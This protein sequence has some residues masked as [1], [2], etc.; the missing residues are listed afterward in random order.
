[1]SGKNVF[2]VL[3]GR[4]WLGSVFLALVFAG[5]AMAA[6]V[7]TTHKDENGW[8]LLV[9]GK[10]YYVKGM[11]WSY[12]PRGEN[13]TYDLWGQPDEFVKKILDYDFSL[14]EKAGVNTIRTFNSIPPKWVT[15][16]YQEY[17]IRTIVNHLAARYGNSYT[18][19]WVANTNYQ[20]P[21]TRAAMK[22]DVLKTVE[23]FKNT[24]GLLMF[25]LGNEANYGLSWSSFE[26]ENFPEGEQNK[27]KA[28]YLYSIYNE[29]IV[30][31]KKITSDVPYTIVNGD[32]QYIDLIKE[33]CTDLDVLGTNVYRG[34]SF[35][36]LWKD[37]DEKLD[38]PVV[39]MEFGSDAFN[40]RTNSEDQ[41]SQAYLLKDQWQELYNKSYGNGEEGNS[42]GGTVFEWRD[43]WWKFKQTENLDKQDNNA[44]WA[45]GGYTSDFREGEN[46]MNEEWWG[47]A[48]LGTS[49]SDGV[50][51]A[52]PRMAYDVLTE[53][54]SIDPFMFKK[55]A[56]NQVFANMNMDFMQLKSDVRILKA[57]NRERKEI[58]S[59][60]GGDF[61]GEFVLKGNEN[62]IDLNGENGVQFSD[63]EMI[64]LDFGFQPT[65]KI[66]GA[67]SVNLL[68]N[69]ADK[70]DIE[71]SY[72]RQRQTVEFDVPD[73]A[74]PGQTITVSAPSEDRERIEIYN[75]EAQY[76]S[77]AFDLDIVL[78]CAA[79][80]L[81]VQ[82]RFLRP[83]ARGD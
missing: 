64:F 60:T 54:W 49:N 44:S 43:E 16:V 50:Y 11:V 18:G 9:N 12:T 76:T 24:T 42:I 23:R 30:E 52:H 70:D 63:Q 72:G 57:E 26:I 8:K 82:G 13:Y 10:D 7:V 25:A 73:P 19:K 68:G 51:E 83:A 20:D 21:L 41:A 81:E 37:V 6:D 55:E 45:N 29:I 53:I 66:K 80:S 35:T 39:L 33:Y 22:A 2:F 31:A 77:K 59:F 28:R 4:S 58:I 71:I 27:E 62:D 69:V 36:S 40:A 14:M 46:N 1:M 32:I 47:I 79:L 34:K 65:D 78:P 61:R 75:F 48:A 67:L 74:N 38:M 17:G 56:I 5:Q 15:Y 3:L